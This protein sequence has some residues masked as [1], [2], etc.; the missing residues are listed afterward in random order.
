MSQDSQCPPRGHGAEDLVDPGGLFTLGRG[1]EPAGMDEAQ[2]LSAA[3][4][5]IF[6]QLLLL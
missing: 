2:Q 6:V 3:L 5:S 4:E 1:R